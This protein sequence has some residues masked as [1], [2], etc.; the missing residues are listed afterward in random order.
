MLFV[1]VQKT[2][3]SSVQRILDEHLPDSTP[4]NPKHGG[5]A[6]TLK[7]HPELADYWTF[8][9]VRNHSAASRTRVA[10]LFHRDIRAFGYDF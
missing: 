4:L 8:G 9:F 3:G 2:G 1:H 6:N 10:D 7:Q 5:L